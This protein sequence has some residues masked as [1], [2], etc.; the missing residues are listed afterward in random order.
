MSSPSV[1]D[2]LMFESLPYE[3]KELVH[4]LF[5]HTN[6]VSSRGYSEQDIRAAYEQGWEDALEEI[7]DAIRFTSPR[8]EIY[9]KSIR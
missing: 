5:P 2:E 8:T 1:S 7:D 4:R 9:I 6:M 3:I